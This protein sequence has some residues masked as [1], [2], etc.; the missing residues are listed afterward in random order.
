MLGWGG[1]EGE[2]LF[3]IFADMCGINTPITAA[4]QVKSWLAKF[5]NI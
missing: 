2:F 5:L 4:F 3:V 1:G